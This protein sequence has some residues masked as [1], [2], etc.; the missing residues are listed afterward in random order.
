MLPF[1]GWRMTSIKAGEAKKKKTSSEISRFLD[2]LA[3]AHLACILPG[4]FVIFLLRLFLPWWSIF[5]VIVPILCFPI[6]TAIRRRLRRKC[7]PS[8]LDT[9]EQPV[10]EEDANQVGKKIN[11]QETL[12][13]HHVTDE[14][15]AEGHQP[16][17]TKKLREFNKKGM[18]EANQSHPMQLFLNQDDTPETKDHHRPECITCFFGNPLDMSGIE[19]YGNQYKNTN[20]WDENLSF[21]DKLRGRKWMFILYVLNYKLS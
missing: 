14:G 7:S 17:P 6:I 16:W 1:V 10:D 18:Y 19:S 4:G 3:Y 9:S 5:F 21:H 20:Q 2:N 15:V 12:T 13:E 11:P 8:S